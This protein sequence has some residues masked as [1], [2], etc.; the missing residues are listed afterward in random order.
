M[1]YAPGSSTGILVAG[2]NGQGN[3]PNQ[4]YEPECSFID[5]NGNLYVS[6]A[7][8]YRVQRWPLSTINRNYTPVSSGM[9][10]AVVETGNGCTITTA[11]QKVGIL[12]DI[13][14]TTT[15][16]DICSGKS[17]QFSAELP[18]GSNP[19]SYNWKSQW[20]RRRNE[21]YRFCGS[22]TE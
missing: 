11:A 2:G 21:Q 4:F 18:V 12:P 8:N 5:N 20:Y 15:A 10:T 3:A 7:F 6:D 9:Y 17:I 22:Y 13:K 14:I 19:S 16:A 1:K